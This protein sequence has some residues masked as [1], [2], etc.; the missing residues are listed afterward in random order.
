MRFVVPRRS[1]LNTD[2]L[3]TTHEVAEILRVGPRTIQTWRHLQ[4]GPK[5]VR[6]GGLVRYR[7]SDVD[8]Y[9]DTA[10]VRTAMERKS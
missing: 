1:V 4:R 9:I 6:I 5:F 2:P 10:A 3:L 7:K 8:A